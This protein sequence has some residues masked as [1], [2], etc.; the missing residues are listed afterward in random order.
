MYTDW[1]T[2]WNGPPQRIETKVQRE[3]ECKKWTRKLYVFGDGGVKCLKRQDT[4]KRTTHTY[5]CGCHFN[6]FLSLCVR[7]SMPKMQRTCRHQ[8]CVHSIERENYICQYIIRSAFGFLFTCTGEWLYDTGMD[9]RNARRPNMQYVPTYFVLAQQSVYLEQRLQ[10][11]TERLRVVR[12]TEN[13]LQ[14]YTTYFVCL[15]SNV[16]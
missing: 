8:T 6:R 11:M 7:V 2:K 10:I 9:V 16:V 4:R 12:K 1:R 14:H 5:Y 15:S 13:A 3:M